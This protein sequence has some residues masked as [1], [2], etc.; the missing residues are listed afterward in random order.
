[1]R[2]TATIVGQGSSIDRKRHKQAIQTVKML[3]A[4]IVTYFTL[5]LPISLVINVKVFVS[6]QRDMCDLHLHEPLL[7]LCEMANVVNPYIL[8]YFNSTIRR[9]A[10][11]TFLGRTQTD[12]EVR[13]TQDTDDGRLNL[14]D[15]LSAFI[16]DRL[17]THSAA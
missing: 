10:L 12:E 14:K 6:G 17:S 9:Q 2:Q 15:R 8:C 16:S 13:A 1:M 11:E 7:V 5:S 4:L 3:I